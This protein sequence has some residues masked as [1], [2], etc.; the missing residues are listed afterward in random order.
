MTWINLFA[1]AL[2]LGYAVWMVCQAWKLFANLLRAN[3][4][5]EVLRNIL[6]RR[7]FYFAQ[8]MGSLI[9]LTV[10][11]GIKALLLL[12]KHSA[13][14]VFSV[15]VFGD[16]TNR[17]LPGKVGCL[18]IILMGMCLV[19]FYQHLKSRHYLEV[20]YALRDQLGLPEPV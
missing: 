13:A 7:R 4:A 12:F 20:L 8:G 18:G 9:A 19:C 16:F 17:L 10:F 2:V 14:N 3:T 11:L 6:E 1:I 5:E 15:I